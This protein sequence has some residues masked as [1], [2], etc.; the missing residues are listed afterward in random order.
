[1]YLEHFF[2][3]LVDGVEPSKRCYELDA[4]ERS[5]GKL[6]DTT[7]NEDRCTDVIDHTRR[8]AVTDLGQCRGCW[9]AV[10]SAVLSTYAI[11]LHTQPAHKRLV[12][13]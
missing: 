9:S 12:N 1:M 4:G 6:I 7:F 3:L 10:H 5:L 11:T 13:I 2:F 8:V